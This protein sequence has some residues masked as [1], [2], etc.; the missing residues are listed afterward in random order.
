MSVEKDRDVVP[1]QKWG[2]QSFLFP[3]GK[4]G[5][6]RIMTIK[7]CVRKNG[8]R[9]KYQMKCKTVKYGPNYVRS[10]QFM[11]TEIIMDAI[12]RL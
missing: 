1:K 5:F 7:Y 4:L 2:R 3:I 12:T 11:K 8:D 9:V 10:K 6:E